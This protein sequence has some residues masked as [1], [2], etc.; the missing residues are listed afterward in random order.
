V[1]VVN[2]D[3]QRE[4][5]TAET[6][7]PKPDAFEIDVAIVKPERHKSPGTDQIPAELI[8]AG[9]KRIRSEVH[10]FINYISK[11][12]ELPEEWRESIIVPFY[13][14]DVKQIV[15]I[16]GAYHFCQLRTKFYSPP[17]VEVNSICRRNEWGYVVF[18]ATGQLLIIYSAFVKY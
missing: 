10:K 12:E 14:K 17:A 15:A 2:D 13:K 7:V 11:K 3:R 18:D 4:I 1:L 16:I 5:H 6:L 9:S 8:K